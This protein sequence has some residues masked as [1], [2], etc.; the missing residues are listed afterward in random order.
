LLRIIVRSPSVAEAI[1][2]RQADYEHKGCK[3]E[4]RLFL[5]FIFYLQLCPHRIHLFLTSNSVTEYNNSVLN[6]T[7]NKFSSTAKHVYVG[8]HSAEQEAFV[9]QKLYTMSGI[10]TGG[11]PYEVIFLINKSYIITTNIDVSHGF[12]SAGK[13]DYQCSP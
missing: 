4:S 5:C 6:S 12:S 7:E 3:F 1:E 10:D 13:E 2:Y 8:C 11:L 9:K